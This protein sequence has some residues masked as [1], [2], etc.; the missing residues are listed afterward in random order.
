MTL[1]SGDD[2]EGFSCDE[3]EG[4]S[5]GD[6]DERAA[7][8]TIGETLQRRTTEVTMNGLSASDEGVNTLSS[9]PLLGNGDYVVGQIALSNK[10]S[11][12]P[13]ADD[14]PGSQVKTLTLIM[15]I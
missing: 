4:S 2:D 15:L 6:E 11:N 13:D 10:Q 3:D 8:T 1:S 5:T 12:S 9:S 7:A 14:K